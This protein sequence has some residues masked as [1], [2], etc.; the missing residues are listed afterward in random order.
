ML[1]SVIIP[2]YN[3]AR[4]L[5]D[6]IGSVLAQTFCDF[7]VI[8]ID[9]G[10]TDDT[11]TVVARYGAAV[12]CIHQPNSG[13][14]VARNRG[15][16]EARGRYVAF[17]DADDTWFPHKLERQVSAL[18][19]HAQHRACYTAFTVVDSSLALLGTVRSKRVGP[20][21]EDLLLRGNVI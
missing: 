2:T 15:I 20:T 19:N 5:P 16:E 12:R 1:V 8:V 21:L 18:D 6:A 10:S 14:A 17:L 7:E 13:V 3:S 4:F 11:E 9:D